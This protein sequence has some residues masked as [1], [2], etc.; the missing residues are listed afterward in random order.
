MHLASLRNQSKHLNFPLNE[1]LCIINIYLRNF[2]SSL[3]L[4]MYYY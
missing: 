2:K 4:E 1:N 3:L